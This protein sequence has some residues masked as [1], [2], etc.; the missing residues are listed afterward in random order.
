MKKVIK[1]LLATVTVLIGSWPMDRAQAEVQDIRIGALLALSGPAA[2]LGDPVQK[3]LRLIVDRYNADGGMSGHKVVLISY[4]TGGSSGKAVQLY[5]R[6][7]ES[8]GAEV[9]IGP[10]TSGETL[11]LKSVANELQ[12]PLISFGASTEIVIPTTAYVFKV[13]PTDQ[14][15]IRQ[16][17]N[18][19]TKRGIKKLGLIYGSDAYG[20]SGATLLQRLA[21]A[22]GIEVVAAE[23]FQPLDSDMTPQILRIRNAAPDA[24]LIWSIDPGA[25]LLVKQAA[26]LGFTKPI[27]NSPAVADPKFLQN[28]GTAALGT[29][30]QSSPLLVASQLPES[31]PQK[32]G[33]VWLTN[34]YRKQ[35]S[36]EPPQNA[37]HPYD[38]L[39]LIAQAV[40]GTT[41]KLTGA[42][43]AEGLAK[44]HGCGANG[45]YQMTAT[46]HNGLP[47]D[48]MV[49]L[50]GGSAGW[51]LDK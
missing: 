47:A 11:T 9:V 14:I 15:E 22:A 19:L 33:L 28:A 27:Y 49:I 45:C 40:E 51:E 44:A 31:D 24:M 43:L 41:G 13:P 34:T 20:Q 38:A 10:S 39:M 42:A 37:G 36:E 25:T 35:Y 46:D 23:Q 8:D 50:K 32:A 7:V 1:T 5:R 12:V 30:V 29:F 2:S 4:D 48:P 3:S 26:A 17:V 18:D 6:L 21:P 16:L